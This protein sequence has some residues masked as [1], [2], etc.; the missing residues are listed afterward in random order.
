M[1]LRKL[2]TDPKE[3][4]IYKFRLASR[5]SQR[6][7]AGRTKKHPLHWIFAIPPAHPLEPRTVNHGSASSATYVADRIK[8]SPD[9]DL[10]RKG[11]ASYRAPRHACTACRRSRD[12]P[13]IDI[14]EVNVL[15]PCSQ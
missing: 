2:D 10:W 7:P 1:P 5:K 14:G 3:A 4:R 13:N 9:V 8:G 6:D 12:E 15:C 11:L